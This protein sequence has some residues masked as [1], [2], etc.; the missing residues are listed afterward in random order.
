MKKIKH[1]NRKK[2][3]LK[4]NYLLKQLILFGGQNVR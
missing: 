3:N 2:N 4:G 1:E